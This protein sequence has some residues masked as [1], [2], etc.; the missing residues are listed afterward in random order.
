M[1]SA[2]AVAGAGKAAWGFLRRIPWQAWAVAAVLFVGWRY[3]EHRYA[4]GVATENTRWTEAQAEADRKAKAETDKRDKVASKTNDTAAAEGAA[5]TTKTQVETAAAVER[6][7]YVTRTIEVPSGCPVAV[8][9]IVRDE[10]R[11]AVDRARAAGSP[12]RA[13]RDP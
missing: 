3:G 2:A 8:P 7:K 13:G 1:I 5:A 4:A 11:A 10:G 9:D 6:V 12:L